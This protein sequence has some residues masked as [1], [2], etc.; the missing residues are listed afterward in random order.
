LA[1][2]ELS[3]ERAQSRASLWIFSISGFDC[4]ADEHY[5]YEMTCLLNGNHELS[6]A[7]QS[8]DVL[9]GGLVV[10]IGASAGGLAAF[11]TF[12]AH[13]PADSGMAFILV[14][15]LDPNHKSLLV[16][17]LGAR[18]PIPV[19]EAADGV[20]IRENCVFVIPPDATLTIKDGILRVASPAPPR[21]VRRPIDTFLSSLAEDCGD[22]AVGII[23]SGVGS[24]GALGVRGIKEHG[25]LTLAQA[26]YNHVAQGGMPQ[27]AADTGMVDHVV[28]IEAMPA[29]LVDYRQHLGTVAEHKDGNGTRTDARPHLA[30][31]TGLLRAG[32]DHDFSGY[33]EN[34]LLR[35]IQRRMQVLRIDDVPNYVE[36]LKTDRVELEALFRELLI[37]VTQFFRDTDAF[38]ALK[39]TTLAPLVSGRTANEPIRV[40]VPGC[41]T[42]EEVYSIAILLSECTPVGQRSLA[43]DIK[44][45]GSDIDGNAITVA[46]AGRYRQPVTGVSPE[47]LGRWFV[48]DGDYYLLRREI[49]EL[50]TFSIHSIVKDPPFSRLDLISCRNVLIYLEPE[51]QNRLMQTFHYALKPGGFL[52]LGTSENI[53]R[54]AKQFT[55]VDKEHHIFG[56]RDTGE[57]SLPF[58]RPSAATLP[59]MPY[60]R[61]TRGDEDRIDRS[62]RRIMEQYAPAYFVIDRQHEIRRFSGSEARHYLEPSPGVANL[63]LFS[64]LQKTLRPAVRAAVEEALATEKTVINEHLMIQIDGKTRPLTLI[65]EPVSSDGAKDDGLC[66]VAFR[67][68]PQPADEQPA[69]QDASALALTKELGA[70]KAQLQAATDQLEAYIEDMKSTTEEY[71]AVTEEL[72][73]SNEELETAKE[74]LQSINEELQ[75]V[76]GELQSKNEAME[77]LNSDLKNL[78]DSTHIATVF[79]DDE[80]R[81]KHFTPAMEKLF[82]LREGDRGRPITDVVGQLAYDQ[83]R[84]DVQEVQRSLS[85]V[86]RELDLKG[87][88]ASFLMRIRPY[89]T[90]QNVI[91][92]V[93]ITFTDITTN[94]R[95]QRARELFID[96][97]HHRTR[98]LL[99][100]VQSIS[101]TTL[102]AAGSLADYGA[103]FNNRL[104]A[105][106]RVQG[107]LSRRDGAAVP[108][109]EIV[110]AELAAVGVTPI[111]E[112][113]VV[114]GPPVTLPHDDMQLLALALHELATNALKYGVLNG[115]RGRLEVRWQ[116]LDQAENP[117]LELTWQESG[118]EVAQQKAN[119]SHQ[120]YGRELLEHA[121][122]YQLGAKTRLELGKD[123]MRFWLAI[124]LQSPNR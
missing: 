36:R 48:K 108:L 1:L 96:E 118:V 18:S 10:G 120:G 40:W 76:N 106:A 67:E 9:P 21:E 38:E 122:P 89:R 117:R 29:L 19:L 95:L 61:S 104:Q 5:L 66:V 77:H 24:D 2:C 30:A 70:T 56:R 113:I 74:E 23:L 49:R 60:P 22:K 57:L 41:S 112:H 84:A 31:I 47:R 11:K 26:E 115:A 14:Q 8:R 55:V 98:N 81:I 93:V 25:G 123:G 79:L 28:P 80:L 101:G 102:A 105:I 64:L 50:C 6:P 12:L 54:H 44:I 16:D 4:D 35:R 13:T 87:G 51:L 110:Q 45:F 114:A 90:T 15:H 72:Q 58:S 124:P 91:D 68:A 121:L 62:V 43:N 17:L 94:K 32:I 119:P 27:S 100:V 107:F 111:G 78:L 63:S 37:S 86:E 52:F 97:L 20:A 33:K 69:A 92:G 65:V 3:Y 59:T 75:T 34:T 109:T 103:E 99:S 83:L 116:I 7:P 73:S 46:R 39:S 71:Q 85:F 42:G 53:T 82:P 88:A